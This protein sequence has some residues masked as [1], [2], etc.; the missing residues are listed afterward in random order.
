MIT[1]AGQ[2][3]AGLTLSIPPEVVEAV[4]QRIA[5]II[6]ERGQDASSPWLTRKE[7]AEYLS[8]PVS[9]LEKDRALPSHR[10]EGRVL[11]NRYEL[12]EHLLSLEA[13]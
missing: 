2:A 5:T 3:E 4:A 12:D 1:R 6:L 8:V 13:A 9:R 10:W 7:A 11:Y